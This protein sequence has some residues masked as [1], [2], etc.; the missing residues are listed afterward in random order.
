MATAELE[1]GVNRLLQRLEEER[2]YNRQLREEVR[3]RRAIHEL[4]RRVRAGEEVALRE[5]VSPKPVPDPD[6]VI[7]RWVERLPP[8]PIPS[9]LQE[10]LQQLAAPP[11]PPVE[12]S[13]LQEMETIDRDIAASVQAFWI[14]SPAGTVVPEPTTALARYIYNRIKRRLRT[15]LINETLFFQTS[16]RHADWTQVTEFRN[17]VLEA[18]LNLSAEPSKAPTPFQHRNVKNSFVMALLQ[19]LAAFQQW[20]VSTPATSV[21]YAFVPYPGTSIKLLSTLVEI[22]A[23][24]RDPAVGMMTRVGTV[25]KQPIYLPLVVWWVAH[26]TGSTSFWTATN[27]ELTAMYGTLIPDNFTVRRWADMKA[28]RSQV[29]PWLEWSRANNSSNYHLYR[30]LHPS[31]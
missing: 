19:E 13:V 24:I 21:V 20:L 6:E 14:S 28:L 15:G 4:R 25:H 23:V 31:R 5:V 1:A 29:R 16:P 22:P 11:Q 30:Q 10:K 17:S 26:D 8:H 12:E 7:A 27:E 18:M 3:Q 2:A 9:T